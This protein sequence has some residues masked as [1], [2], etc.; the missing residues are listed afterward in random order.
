MPTKKSLQQFLVR[1]GTKARLARRD[2]DWE[3]FDI[4]AS[5]RK[6]GVKEQAKLALQESLDDLKREQEMLWS[7]DQ[8]SLLV[9][10]QAMDA[11]GKDGMIKHVMSGV[12]PQG[13]DVRSFKQP[14]SEE[15]DHSFLWRAMKVAPERGK[16]AIFNRSHYEDVLVVKVHPELLAKSGLPDSCLSK[17]IWNERYE[18]IVAFERHLARNGTKI[19]KFF[20]HISKDEQRKRF[21]ERLNDPSKHWKFSASDVAERK[22]WDTYQAVYEDA[23]SATSTSFAPWYVIPSNNKWVARSLVAEIIAT[24]ISSLKLSFPKVTR[25]KRKE[26]DAARRGLT[27][28]SEPS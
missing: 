26:L 19:L 17:N 11:A 4:F 7:S 27:R 25:L 1:P 16:I 3:S 21:L 13:C 10:L 18:D 24:E 12:N 28:E 22:H 14:S 5:A 2:P 8:Y 6:G 9:V 20:L 15:L 23:L